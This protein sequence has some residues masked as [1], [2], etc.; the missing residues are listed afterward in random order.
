MTVLSLG[1]VRGVV[2]QIAGTAFGMALV[3]TLICA[4]LGAPEAYILNRMANPWKSLFLLA[5]L[6]PLL[7]S[8]VV[9]TLAGRC[10]SARRGRST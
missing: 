5:V 1:L 9:R 10:C 2:A 7:I 3:V 4:L 8:V 6:G